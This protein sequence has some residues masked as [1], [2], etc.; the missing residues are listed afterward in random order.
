MR[1]LMLFVTAAGLGLGACQ[2]APAERTPAPAPM[3]APPPSDASAI[4]AGTLLQVRLDNEL[5]T[6]TSRVGDTFTVTVTEP[7]I[8]ANRQTVVPEGATITGMVT[9]V[10]EPRNDNPAVIRLNF[11]RVNVGGAY[12]PL[13]AEVT[14]THVPMH[15][16]VDMDAAARAAAAGA[17]A[18]AVL[19][20]II[21]GELRDALIGAILGAG[22]GTIISL[23]TA[24]T[25]AVLPEGTH[26]TLRTSTRTEL[27]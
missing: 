12:H 26:M 25:E 13:T 8:A 22:A 17:V 5:S 7:L 1:R 20:A 11:L 16:R 9:G 14:E 18:G 21:T 4:P 3:P 2:T 24:D 15:E 23:G 19:G 27:R 10:S 6:T